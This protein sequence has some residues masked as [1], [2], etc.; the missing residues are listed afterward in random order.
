MMKRA[1]RKIERLKPGLTKL[2][3]YLKIPLK[4]FIYLFLFKIVVFLDCL[5]L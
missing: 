2:V 5:R 1:I 3:I 4:L